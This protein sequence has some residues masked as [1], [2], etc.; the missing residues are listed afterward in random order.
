[1]NYIITNFTSTISMN[2]KTKNPL[3]TRVVYQKIDNFKQNIRQR[4]V[5]KVQ[6]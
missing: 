4:T 1:M 6:Y 5:F 2:L 3:R